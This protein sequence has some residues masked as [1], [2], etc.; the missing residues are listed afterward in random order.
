MW[1]NSSLPAETFKMFNQ[2][3]STYEFVKSDRY[4]FILFAAAAAN[5]IFIPQLKQC[6][7]AG[8]IKIV[9][10]GWREGERLPVWLVILHSD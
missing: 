7:L 5:F 3:E 9:C 8:K 10:W 4:A 2:F 1:S 6:G